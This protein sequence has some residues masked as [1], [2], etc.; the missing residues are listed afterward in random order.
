[1]VKVGVPPSKSIFFLKLLISDTHIPSS[2]LSGF[3]LPWGPYFRGGGLRLSRKHLIAIRIVVVEYCN[4]VTQSKLSV[5]IT[6]YVKFG[7][8]KLYGK[9]RKKPSVFKNNNTNI[10]CC[11]VWLFLIAFTGETGT[12]RV[13]TVE[14]VA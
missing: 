5:D 12:C 3:R 9:Y 10:F 1:M 11:I 2:K 4:N 8:Q 13:L 14:I 7:Q 6:F